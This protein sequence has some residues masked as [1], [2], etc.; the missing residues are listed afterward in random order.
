MSVVEGYVCGGGVCLWWRGMSEVEGYVVTWE[1][2]GTQVL[3]SPDLECL[4]IK[5]RPHYL[6]R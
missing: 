4:T 6:P 5:W 1:R 2:T 3:C